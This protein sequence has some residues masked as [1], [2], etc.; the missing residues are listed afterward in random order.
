MAEVTG[1]TL[2]QTPTVVLF[3]LQHM[4]DVRSSLNL[5][6]ILVSLLVHRKSLVTGSIGN[7]FFDKSDLFF[8]FPQV[9]LGHFCS[10]FQKAWLL[11]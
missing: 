5:S 10:T 1:E 8:N 3:S 2:P 6:L 7:F 9:F 4:E 11:S